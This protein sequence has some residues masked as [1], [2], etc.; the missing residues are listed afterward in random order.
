MQSDELAVAADRTVGP[1]PDG[2][3]LGVWSEGYF[4]NDT[5]CVIYTWQVNVPGP[6]SEP[7]HEGWPLY[8]PV[9]VKV[10]EERHL[11][12]SCETV[13]LSRPPEFRD[14]GETLMS[15]PEEA[16]VSRAWTI[17]ERLN[18]PAEMARARLLDEEANRAGE[19]VGVRG[20]ITTNKVETRNTR[21]S[22][23]DRGGSAWLWC[24]A[25]NPTNDHE[26]EG[27]CSDLP[28]AHGHYWALHSPR[29]FARALGAMFVDQVGP[30]GQGS[31]L[32]QTFASEAT[33]HDSQSVFHGPVVYVD[34]PYGYVAESATPLERL[35][36]PM[37]VKRL[38]YEH[39]REY[40][41][42]VWDESEPEETVLLLDASSALLDTA[43][44]LPSGPVPV[45]RSA[46]TPRTPPPSPPPLPLGAA[47][48]PDSDSLAEIAFAMLNDPH[49]NHGVRTIDAEDL[50]DDLDE[51]TVIY[52]AVETLRGI[53]DNAG[54]EPEAAAA[55][56]HAEP[57]IR[58]LCAEFQDPIASIRLTPDNFIV[59]KVKFPEGSDAY[60]NIAVGPRGMVR[61]KIGK[62][63]EYTVTTSDSTSPFGW[64]FLASF[65][66]VLSRYG[67]PSRRS[68]M[69]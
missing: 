57:Y 32:K 12:G 55:A 59:I 47:G 16:R 25:I 31:S 40:R 48:A 14:A 1:R 8:L 26:W 7:S 52:P 21:R 2:S 11:I 33:Q 19:L 18:D 68:A 30:R 34:D 62:G 5:G 58:C 23:E 63:R 29:M 17:D 15:D 42:V 54:S 28:P 49:I 9:L 51:K 61:H 3:R 66:K 46:P 69:G 60:G 64:P 13:K 65:E 67:L 22:A 35:L 45:S 27:L 37:F 44:D 6:G 43:R 50:P 36:R 38:E 53:V 24:S 39:Q 4:V 41:F 20:T 10:C 56:W